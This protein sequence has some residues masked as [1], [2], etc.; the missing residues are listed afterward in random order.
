M[1]HTFIKHTLSALA[2]GALTS[3]VLAHPGHIE[4]AGHGHSHLLALGAVCVA[5]VV[6]GYGLLRSL[7]A[8]KSHADK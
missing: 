4:A 6:G 5:L 2:L 1:K 8:R 3:P 7:K